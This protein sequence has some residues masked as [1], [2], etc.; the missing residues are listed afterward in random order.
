MATPQIDSSH[1]TNIHDEPPERPIV[2]F[3]EETPDLLRGLLESKEPPIP[4]FSEALDDNLNGGLRRKALIGIAGLPGN[5][6]TTFAWQLAQHIA[7]H[8]KTV[9]AH[10]VPVPCLYVSLE[11]SKPTLYHKALSRIGRIDG[12][13]L[14]SR[15]WV[16]EPDVE[17]KDRIL[18]DIVKANTRFNRIAR[19]LG[20]LDMTQAVPGRMTIEQLRENA[21]TFLESYR[22]HL[23]LE[24]MRGA[25]DPGERE[26][27]SYALE[28]DPH[29]V[30]FVDHL[31]LLSAQ[32]DASRDGALPHDAII[33][34]HLKHLA[35]SIDCTV[36]ALSQMTTAEADPVVQGADMTAVL[37]TGYKLIDEKIKDLAK[38]T[39]EMASE[40]AAPQE[41]EEIEKERTEHEKV[42]SQKP[43]Q[44]E[45]SPIYAI[46][47]IEKNR[48]GKTRH[49][50]FVW[51]RAFHEFEEVKEETEDVDFPRSLMR[52]LTREG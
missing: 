48:D 18:K 1:E 3:S 46:L 37:R 24:L 25:P 13:V 7:E 43:L 40:D 39:K 28:Q 42:R 47:D 33:S 26:R 4:T 50:L 35:V 45:G 44:T 5:G 38:E 9:A 49:A 22:A 19:H 52:F 14:S 11:L 36:V 15:R 12:G 32:P 34:Y 8:G 17:E 51:R 41:R 6:K 10:Q 16:T 27:L 23:E 30:I 2:P 21:S 29:L 20:V 31:Q